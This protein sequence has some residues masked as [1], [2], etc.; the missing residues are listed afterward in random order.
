[1]KRFL[2]G[3]CVF[4]FAL[5]AGSFGQDW[6]G[7][8]VGGN[9]GGVK[10][11]SHVF[12]YTVFSPTGYFATSSIPAIAFDGNSHLSPRGFT[13]GG[14][15]G[16][17]FQHGHWIF[18]A[19]ADFGAMHV[20]DDTVTTFTYPCCAPTNFT[21][22]Q[23]VSTDWLFTARPRIGVGNA[24]FVV[25]GTGGLAMTNLSYKE[26]FIDTFATAHESAKMSGLLTGWVAGGGVDFK[27]N[28]GSHWSARAEYLHADFGS[29]ITTTSNN[30]TAFGPPVIPFPT[31]VFTH[32]ADLTQNI[33]RAAVNYR[34]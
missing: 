3:S 18:G 4:V 13:G 24:Y 26:D 15:A 20:S 10:G 30:L 7:F 19:E 5:V 23:A 12:T 9:A 27:V 6:N 14:Q 1:V 8:Y 29:G 16:Y 34:F 31:N 33:F 32:S 17:T 21:I 22:S 11:D 28:A 2:L 25:Y